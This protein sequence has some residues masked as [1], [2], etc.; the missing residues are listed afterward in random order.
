MHLPKHTI[1]R[2]TPLFAEIKE[3]LIWSCL[4]AYKKEAVAKP[5]TISIQVRKPTV[6]S[7]RTSGL[8][9]FIFFTWERFFQRKF[10]AQCR[11]T[12]D[13]YMLLV[14]LSL[15]SVTLRLGNISN[16]RRKMI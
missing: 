15:V 10:R 16:T 11:Q 9:Q 4:Q 13:N 14:F 7:H 5:T 3:T 12:S 8:V 6:R 1:S 2:I